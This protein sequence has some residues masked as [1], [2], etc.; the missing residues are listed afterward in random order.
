MARV[1][2]GVGFAFELGCALACKVLSIAGGHG[3]RVVF[4]YGGFDLRPPGRV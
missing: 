3:A 2:D 1:G 4:Q